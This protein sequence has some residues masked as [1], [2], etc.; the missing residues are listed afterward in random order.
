MSGEELPAAF[1]ISE[2]GHGQIRLTYVQTMVS[3]LR[4]DS[5]LSL[6][7]RHAAASPAR[8]YAHTSQ[9]GGIL[10]KKDFMG[11]TELSWWKV[12]RRR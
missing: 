2:G 11:L 10:A 4:S 7:Y 8:F 6:P 3:S 12:E 9:Q 1:S 5:E